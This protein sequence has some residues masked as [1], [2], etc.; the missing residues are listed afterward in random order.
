MDPTCKQAAIFVA[1]GKSS[2]TIRFPRFSLFV[3]YGPL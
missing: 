1:T 3:I 2:D